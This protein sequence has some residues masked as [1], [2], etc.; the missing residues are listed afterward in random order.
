MQAHVDVDARV[1][2]LHALQRL[3]LAFPRPA[4]LW[5][6][7]RLRQQIGAILAK[8]MA[9]V[10]AT[11]AAPSGDV[12]AGIAQH[13]FRVAAQLLL[14]ALP[15]TPAEGADP[16]GDAPGTAIAVMV[17][18]RLLLARKGCWS[19]LVADL[20]ADV[21]RDMDDSA[22]RLPD[23]GL[24]TELEHDGVPRIPAATAQS[25]VIRARSGTLKRAPRQ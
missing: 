19:E 25:A 6:P 24:P 8:L 5:V 14:R 3:P 23:A 1:D 22:A 12:E 9:D 4:L 20:A 11:M 10:A 2:L 16:A 15:R 21:Q 13:V 7:R 17:R 18:A